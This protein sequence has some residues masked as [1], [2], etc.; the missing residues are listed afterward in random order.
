M[1]I[2]GLSDQRRLP[3]IGK[4]HLGYKV[5]REDGVEYPRAAQHFVYPPDHPQLEELI[6]TYGPKPT[7]LRVIIPV[8]DD[9]KFASQYYRCY[10]R[11]RGLICKGDGET[12]VRM[13]DTAT[14]AMANRYTKEAE[15]QEIPC[16]GRECP[17]YGRTG[18]G[19]VMNLQF[20]LP[21]VS[22]F[23]VWQIDTGSINSIIN[24]NSA[25]D[26]VRQVYGRVAMVPL[27][28][29][30][31]PK[32]VTNPDDGKKKTVRVLNLRSQDKMLEAYRKASMPPL[33]LVQEVSLPRPD[34]DAI[35]AD[36]PTVTEGNGGLD[37]EEAWDKIVKVADKAAAIEGN[38]IAGQAYVEEQIPVIGQRDP[39]PMGRPGQKLRVKETNQILIWIIRPNN[40]GNWY[41]EKEAAKMESVME[42]PDEFV[43]TVTDKVPDDDD[44][45]VGIDMDWV[46]D[47]LKVLKWKP[48]TAISW[49]TVNI[50]GINIEG[51]LAKVLGRLTNEEHQVFV[52]EIQDRLEMNQGGVQ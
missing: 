36:L 49:L 34:E 21:E 20:L 44:G 6:A 18:C 25:V 40:V 3:R 31:E 14:G 15:L 33:E 23:G 27:I 22:G 2:K 43:E 1:P 12:A 41:S 11:T 39:L 13:V 24:I 37:G 50:P 35:F 51:T 5:K 4:I 45:V 38:V 52:K 19:E 42:A 32:E 7:E 16:Q 10:S 9:E 8:E 47:S 30:L 46:K 17:D 28:L 48:Q 29:A 26:L